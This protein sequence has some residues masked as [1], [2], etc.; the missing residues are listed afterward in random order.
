MPLL[1]PRWPRELL[2]EF[3]DLAQKAGYP[4]KHFDA[5][6]PSRWHFLREV[7]AFVRKNLDLF[8]PR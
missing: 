4:A 6:S 8:R 2:D 1:R 7:F 3:N 5:R